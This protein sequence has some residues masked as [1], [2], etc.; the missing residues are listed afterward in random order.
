MKAIY[1]LIIGFIIIGAGYF[2][3]EFHNNTVAELSNELIKYKTNDSTN[4]VKVKALTDKSEFVDKLKEKNNVLS[5]LLQKSYTDKVVY[6]TE[7]KD[8]ILVPLYI[9]DTLYNTDTIH[10]VHKL[11]YKGNY[12]TEWDSF[13]IKLDTNKLLSINYKIKNTY[14]VWSVENK[15]DIDVFVQNMNPNTYTTEL[16]AYKVPKTK[17]KRLAWLGGGLIG[18]LA[19]SL[20][21]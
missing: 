19:I 14:K 11:E 8:T 18:G 12:K 1:S 13:N 17:P 5:Q 9:V 15:N 21:K 16:V 20:L 6:K 3:L 10:K 4:I 7:T 2:C